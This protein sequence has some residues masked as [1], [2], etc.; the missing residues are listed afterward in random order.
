M[1]TVTK[2]LL[3][4]LA[5]VLLFSTTVNAQGLV[6][7]F[8]NKTCPNAETI[9]RDEVIDILKKAKTL[10]G[11]LLRMFFHDCFVNG[12]DGSV[13]LNGTKKDPAE[14]DSIPN[15]SLRGFSAIDKVKAKLEAACPKTVSCADIVA[16]VA[17]D[18][19]VL[20]N[21]PT[22]D[23]PTGRRDGN[24]SVSND[25]LFNL[26][27]PFVS[28]QQALNQ[29]YIPKG[30]NAKDQLVLSGGHTLGNSHCSS[31]T[32]RLYDFNK[33]KKADPRIEKYYKKKL[34]E[35]CK[36][37]DQTTLVEMDPGSFLTFDNGYFK[38][39]YKGRSLFFSDDTLLLDPINEAYIKRQA[40]GNDTTEF[41]ND[42]AASMIKMGNI[43]VLTG[44]QGEI[45]KHCALVN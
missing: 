38:Q 17:R 2:S 1:V 31:F 18:V 13:L 28:A 25:A 37:N 9:I 12:C 20:T 36:P 26:P 42:F 33:T 29:F 3:P 24:R 45:R 30:L 44:T 21:G 43:Q 27:P 5:I 11:P 14:K 10:A 16:I 4:I 6:V 40:E 7:G 8:Y 15:L 22:W 19:V 32:D 34:E 39:L 23:V 41:F 35:K